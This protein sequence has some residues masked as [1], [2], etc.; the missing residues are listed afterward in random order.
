MGPMMLYKVYC[1]ALNMKNTQKQGEITFYCYEIYWGQ[2]TH[3]K[4]INITQCFK[5]ILP[6]LALT[7]I[8]IG[9]GY[10]IQVMVHDSGG[11]YHK[12]HWRLFPCSLL[13]YSLWEK[14][15]AICWGLHRRNEIF[16][17]KAMWLS[18]LI[19][20]S[21]NPVKPSDGSSLNRLPGS[22]ILRNA[23]PELLANLY[24]NF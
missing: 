11:L 16:L 10:K 12:R 18:N 19:S 1:I 17:P 22:N 7:T 5:Q 14:P 23:M 15:T 2:T 20:E 9:G 8:A 4:M 6:T 21:H 3:T 13:D 24:L